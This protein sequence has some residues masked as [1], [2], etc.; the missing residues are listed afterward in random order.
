MS[1]NELVHQATAVMIR[2]PKE[3]L[4]E[5]AHAAQSLTEWMKNKLKPVIFN[6]EQYPE[7]EDW[8]LCGKFYHLT[9]KVVWTRPV[10][11]GDVQG[12]EAGADC[13]DILSGQVVSSAESMCLNDEEKWSKRTKYEW[14]YVCKDGHKQTEDPGYDQ[15]TWEDNPDKPGKKRPK[16][17]RVNI[18]E[19]SVPLFQL[20]SMAQTRACAKSLRNVL[21]WVFV[22]A[23]FKP[24]IAEELTGDEFQGRGEDPNEKD[25]AKA[26]PPATPTTTGQPA[27]HEAP[28]PQPGQTEPPEGDV[29]DTLENELYDFCGGD[30]ALMETKLQGL[31]SFPGMKKDPKTNKYTKEPT[32]QMVPGPRTVNELRE[33]GKTAWAGSALKKLRDEVA[34]G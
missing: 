2:K 5:A 30:L 14:Q 29:F 16:K 15:I 25:T 4:A 10:Q 20:R 21:S 26:H 32:G 3:I 17:E 6:G 9:A 19:V 23:G 13:I 1:E 33:K 28:T 22:L 7:F 12:F 24:N 31:T 27:K 8:Q 34:K 11:F 18:G